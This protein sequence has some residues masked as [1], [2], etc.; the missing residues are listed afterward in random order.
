MADESGDAGEPGYFWPSVPR[1]ARETASVLR[2]ATV[3]AELLRR[4][5]KVPAYRVPVLV[6]PGYMA[7]D[8][9]MARMERLLHLQGHPTM[10]ARIGLNVGCTMDLVDRLEERLET[11]AEQ[12][13]RTVAIVGWSRGG[14]LAKL[15]TMR[16]P[17]LAAGLVT[18]A[19]PNVQPLA[20]SR[21]VNLHLRFLTRLNAVGARMVLGSDCVDGACALRVRDALAEPFPRGIPYTAF[22][23]RGDGVVDWRACLDPAAECVEVHA[24]HMQMGANPHVIAQVAARLAALDAHPVRESLEQASTA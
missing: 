19:S 16:R 2:M 9:T 14:M 10:A 6:I 12:R 24:T 20:V 8:W 4:A 7:G 21:I 11:F 15:L 22:Y 17:D 23:S 3:P 13:E 5:P 1:I 18:L